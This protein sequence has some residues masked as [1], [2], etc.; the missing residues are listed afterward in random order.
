MPKTRS[1]NTIAS[2][3]SSSGSSGAGIGVGGGAGG[4]IAEVEMAQRLEDRLDG[5]RSVEV[6]VESRTRGGIEP[7][8]VTLDPA[9]PGIAT[10]ESESGSTY[11]VNYDNDECDCMHYRVRGDGCRHIDAT[12]M[13]IGRIMNERSQN[14]IAT[15]GTITSE[16]LEDALEDQQRI[17]YDAEEARRALSGEL[18]DDGFFYTDHPEEFESAL[19]RLANDPLPYEYHNV[20]NGSNITFGI[21][22]EFIEGDSDAIARELHREG[23]CGNDRMVPYRSRGVAGKWKLE[24][25]GSV[26]YGR[27]GG[28]LV[29]PVLQ[30][31]PETWETIEKICEIAKRH[32]ARIN[33]QCGGHVHVSMEPLDTARQRWR[34]FFKA[35]AG[36]EEPIYR[37]SGGQTGSI[38]GNHDI[39]AMPFEDRARTGATMRYSMDNIENLHQ[40]VNQVSERDRYYGINLTNISEY[41]RPDTVEFRYFNGSLEPSIIQANIKTA[42]GVIGISEKARTRDRE[43]GEVVSDTMKRRGG[44]INNARNTRDSNGMMQFID[45][46]FTRKKDKEHILGVLAK[47]RWR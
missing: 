24:S 34:R 3:G 1:S 21:E 17:D 18:E 35:I 6:N 30:D 12:H 23:I 4:P 14:G 37:F 39:Y 5:V 22:L 10:V 15:G 33:G 42:V 8:T 40:M 47:N 32:G 43:S 11:Q 28:E 29:S 7:V 31:T 2:R 41:G 46:F 13:A 26:T 25:D 27:R 9:A 19:E 16:I 45:T 36:N 20:L 44:M 38:R